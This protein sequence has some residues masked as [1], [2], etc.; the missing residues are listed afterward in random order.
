MQN[1]LK[2]TAQPDGQYEDLST[3]YSACRQQYQRY[4]GHVQRYLGGKFTNNAPGLEP[5]AIV[6]GK[7]QKEAVAWLGEYV[8]EAP[9]WLYPQEVISKTG[10]DANLEIRNQQST[11]ISVFLSPVLIF[12][13]YNN[14]LSANDAYPVAEYLDDIFALV[15]KPIANTDERQNNYLRQQQRAYVDAVGRILNPTDEMQRSG[16]GAFQSD[17]V[18]F[19]EQHLDKI[20]QYLKSQADTPHYRNLLL[21]IKK[22]HEKYESGKP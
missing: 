19:A 12:N 8:L 18:L 22:I 10:T 13:M 21:R 14:Q 20:E 11:L 1:I 16:A 15:W 6:P 3:I 2:W 9:M 7:T 5:N 17:V 4:T